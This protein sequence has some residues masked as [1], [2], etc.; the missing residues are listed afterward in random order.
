MLE[1]IDDV[2]DSAMKAH[3]TPKTHYDDRIQLAKS[4]NQFPGLEDLAVSA[5]VP[6]YIV[7]GCC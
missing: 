6:E 4:W 5:G 3:G 1:K 2:A 7:A